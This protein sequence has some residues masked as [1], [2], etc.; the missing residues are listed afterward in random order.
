MVEASGFNLTFV[1]PNGVTEALM[2]LGLRDLSGTAET[3]VRVIIEPINDPPTHTVPRYYTTAEDTT[4]LID[5][6]PY[7]DDPD[8]APEELSLVMEDPYAEANGL[9][10][11]VTFPEGTTSHDLLFEVTDGYL[12]TQVTMSFNVTPVDDPPVIS[13][14]ATFIAIEDQL[15]ILNLTRYIEDVDTPLN[16]LVVQADSPH[17][18][19]ESRSLVFNYTV[20][21][22]KEFVHVLVSDASST[23]GAYL[24]V[25]VEERNDPP[26]LHQIPLQ[27]FVENE[28]RTLDLSEYV[29]DED[30]PHRNMHLTFDGSE[31][32]LLN[33]LEA[34]L[35]FTQPLSHGVVFFNLSD[36]EAEVEGSFQVVVEVSSEPPPEEDEGIDLTMPALGVILLVS[37]AI[38]TSIEVSKV[39][40][41]S[42]LLPLYM[43]LSRE[44]ILDQFTRGKI[45][46]YILA[47]PG[48]HYNSIKRTLDIPNGSFV[49]HLNLLENEGFVKSQRDG[50]YKR[51]YPSDM[52]IPK[53]EF[54]LNETQTKILRIISRSPGI[55]Q[56]EI[57]EI[58]GVT[59]A[60]VSYQMQ[61]LIHLGFV[62]KMRRGMSIRYYLM[63][64]ED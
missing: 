31:L 21:G 55:N 37:I 27:H 20:G 18:T 29:E 34:T 40:L 42:L 49:Y 35:V 62:R 45:Y 25:S 63:V 48:V 58:L 16:E 6:E 61:E 44:E 17:C 8:N 39:W 15:S 1:F 14:L 24:Q 59:S 12:S 22:I 57:A 54:T 41:I 19:V 10:I 23:V 4:E 3:M 51:Y 43:K 60:A 38:L 2:T 53:K 13:T 26:V 36:G 33:G 47:N 11:T 28:M 7:I 5:I 64:P 50:V 30:T 46:G 52:R 56:K 9:L 32:V